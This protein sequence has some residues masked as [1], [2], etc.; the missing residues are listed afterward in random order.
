ML[1][2]LS[3]A[4]RQRREFSRLALKFSGVYKILLRLRETRIAL[5][6]LLVYLSPLAAQVYFKAEPDGFRFGNKYLERCFQKTDHTWRTT[7]LVNKLTGH[8]WRTLSQEFRIRFTFERLGYWAD[9]ENPLEISAEDCVLRGYR[10]EP[11]DRGSR[12]LVIGYHWEQG[13]LEGG[14][15]TDRG[16]PGLDIEVIYT[17]A[18]DKPYSRKQIRVSSPGGKLYFIE[19]LALENMSVAGAE[20]CHQ[21]FGQPVYTD[22]MFFGLEYPAGDNSMKHGRI[23]LCYYPGVQVGPEGLESHSAVWG[24]APWQRT[25][26]AFLD[27]L[28]DIRVAPARPFL[29]YNTWYDMRTPE[30]VGNI[31]A[32]ILDYRNCLER[33]E[34]FKKNLVD[35]GLELNSFVLDE[36]W[37]KYTPFWEIDTRNFPGGFGKLKKALENIDCSL[38]L[39]LGPIGGYGE[40]L[41]LRSEAGRRA[42]LEVSR[43]GYLDHAGPK[44]RRILTDRLVDYIKRYDVNYYKFDGVLYGYGDTDHGYLPGVYSRETHTTALMSLLDTLHAVRPGIFTNITTSNWLSPW[45]LAHTDCVYMGGTDYGWLRSLPSISKRDLAVS[46]RDKVCFDNFQTL[47][48]QFPMNSIMTVGVI[49]GEYQYLGDP[50]ETLDKWTD[51]LIMHFSR[52][53]AMWELYI[54]PQILKEEEWETLRSATRWATSNKDVLLSNTTMVGGDPARR[55]PYGYFHF[56]DQKMILTV[57]NPYIQPAAFRMKLDYEHGWLEPNDE[58]YLPMTVYPYRA[59]EQEGWLSFGKTIEVRLSGYET[60]VIE[61]VRRED[62][63]FPILRNLSFDFTAEGLVLYPEN[64]TEKTTFENNSQGVLTIGGVSIPPGAQNEIPLELTYPAGNLEVQDSRTEELGTEGPAGL[65]G[66][67]SIRLPENTVTAEVAFLL[68]LESGLEDLDPSITDNG[69]V[70]AFRT[71]AG[72]KKSWYW[73]VAPVKPKAPHRIAYDFSS[74]ASKGVAGRLGGW[75]VIHRER[76]GYAVNVPGPGSE[77]A[78]RPRPGG[79]PPGIHRRVECLFDRPVRF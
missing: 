45:W 40:G 67:I 64:H 56:H 34:S 22:E 25:R 10:I 1:N 31:K 11:A 42:G 46:Y 7:W 74:R 5:I 63:D 24:A 23:E 47:K 2:K 17:L 8:T 54:S 49:K 28:K 4:D 41:R 51:N 73:F 14:S 58:V 60:K 35:H 33:I 27:Y 36:G 62:V 37:D 66:E 19:E 50:Q 65:S 71:E 38:G 26:A 9:R 77:I 57:R 43:K 53:L 75:L 48:H 52:G 15:N 3:F 59:V 76:K 32:G 72:E 21:G 78:G 18:E 79:S 16:S 68:E 29:L 44:Y 6:L 20:A 69:E 55:E 70:L 30:R 61:L 12:R 13:L 39:W